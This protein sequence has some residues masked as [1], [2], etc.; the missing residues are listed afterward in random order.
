MRKF[1]VIVTLMLCFALL[2]PTVAWA[3]EPSNLAT[4][5]FDGKDITFP[6][7]KD[8]FLNYKNIMPGNELTQP[9]RLVNSSSK[10]TSFYLK[11]KV[12]EQDEMSAA[13]LARVE[14]LLFNSDLMS[15]KIVAGGTTLYDDK[16]GGRR[17]LSLNDE[18][19]GKYTTFETDNEEISASI[20]LGTLSKNSQADFEVIL[21]VEPTMSNDYADLVANVDWEIQVEAK[22]PSSPI[23]P[24][25]PEEEEDED[26]PKPNPEEEQK[27]P[28]EPE[29]PT[30]NEPE[31]TPTP[32]EP[33][34]QLPPP[35][36]PNEVP[37]PETGDD[38]PIWLCGAIVIFSA[39]MIIVLTK[40]Y[41]KLNV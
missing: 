19:V 13:E 2:L 11:M 37:V 16:A 28:V 3:D 35:V 27:P 40:L 32:S 4:I 21:T 25:N 31:I 1:K 9:M 36:F 20:P 22:N 7:G 17:V 5:S 38:F 26:K 29:K 30:P 33:E 8:L 14:E 34:E 10:K 24:T 23:I 41:R 39:V 15:L 6:Q 18:N 12:A